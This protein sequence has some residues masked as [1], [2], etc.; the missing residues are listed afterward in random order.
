M[1]HN[2]Q[3]SFRWGFITAVTHNDIGLEY[4][5]SFTRCSKHKKKHI[6][7]II[8]PIITPGNQSKTSKILRLYNNP[9]SWN[10]IHN[11]CSF[12]IID[13]IKHEITYHEISSSIRVLVYLFKVLR[14]LKFNSLLNKNG[15]ELLPKFNLKSSKLSKIKFLHFK[16]FKLSKPKRKISGSRRSTV[17][18]IFI[19]MFEK[20]YA[21]HRSSFFMHWS[22]NLLNLYYFSKSFKS[23]IEIK[24]LK[25]FN[26][27]NFII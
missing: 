6:L 27:S 23:I 4:W 2:E 25:F 12:K 18:V 8:A 10:R 19:L 21:K 5:S 16:V 11:G 26:Q 20:N 7:T 1:D 22:F 13:Q 9:V 14:F 17:R 24:L 15:L 3:R